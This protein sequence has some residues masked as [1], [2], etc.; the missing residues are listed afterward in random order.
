M[1]RVNF[2]TINNMYDVFLPSTLT[3]NYDLIQECTKYAKQIKLHDP[4]PYYVKYC[5]SEYLKSVDVV[6][7]DIFASADVDF[8]VFSPQ[9]VTRNSFATH[10]VQKYNKYQNSLA[11]KFLRWFDEQYNGQWHT[12][13]YPFMMRITRDVFRITRKIPRVKIMLRPKHRYK[14]DPTF[15]LSTV[16]LTSDDKLHS[17]D[18]LRIQMNRYMPIFLDLVNH[19]RQQQ[20]EP[21]VSAKQVVASAFAIVDDTSVICGNQHINYP[22]QYKYDALID[23]TVLPRTTI[24]MEIGHA[25]ELY[26]HLIKRM[27]SESSAYIKQ[28]I[29]YTYYLK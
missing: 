3:D 14:D 27:R 20:N 18:A 25:A 7:N 6:I 13:T 2:G 22:Q 21:V 15:E 5:F 17:K 1:I 12:G 11:F 10:I 4:D 9:P 28:L 23:L 19:K 24:K 16:G 8:G 26:T 29:K